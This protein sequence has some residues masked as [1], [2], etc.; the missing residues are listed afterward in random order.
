MG[1]GEAIGAD[2]VM[3]L[4]QGARHVEKFRDRN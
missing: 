1:G 2:K 4:W 3:P